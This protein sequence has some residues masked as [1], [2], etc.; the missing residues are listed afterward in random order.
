MRPMS[1]AVRMH[2]LLSARAHSFDI[3]L[4]KSSIAA[5]ASQGIQLALRVPGSKEHAHEPGVSG[6]RKLW[7][8]AAIVIAVAE[9]IGVSAQGKVFK[10]GVDMV[11]LTVT[12]TDPRGNYMTG[13]TGDDFAVFEDGERQPIAFFAGEQLPLDVALVL[14]TSGSMAQSM[15]MVRQSATGLIRNLRS[16]DR[17]AV[18]AQS[19]VGR[20]PAAIDLRSRTGR[21]RDRRVA[22]GRQS[23]ALRRALHGAQRICASATR[24]AGG[25][26][27]GTRGALRR[28]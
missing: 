6:S 17:S 27:S 9:S 18:T 16:G 2:A 13:L 5:N 4:R 22:C 26:A 24:T 21:G 8:A 15:P 11:P 1:V 28:H 14:D 10:S 19:I 20:R 23:R 7:L 25:Q 3:A 12:V